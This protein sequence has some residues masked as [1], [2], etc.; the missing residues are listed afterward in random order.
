MEKNIYRFLLIV[1]CVYL[2][3]SSVSTTAHA[4]ELIYLGSTTYN[5]AGNDMDYGEAVATDQNGNIIVTGDAYNGTNS[6]MYTIKYDQNF[7]IIAAFAFDEGHSEGGRDVIVDNE[8]NI[9]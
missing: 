7:N 9:I 5:G 3:L 4:L 6:D 1:G 2:Y 8:G